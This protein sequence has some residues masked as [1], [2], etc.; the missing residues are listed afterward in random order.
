MADEILVLI[1]TPNIGEAHSIANALVAERLA[2]CVNIV[3]AIE[4]VYRWEGE[5]TRESETLLM[6]KTTNDRYAGV[7]RRVKELHSYSTPE[8][9]AVEIALGSADYLKWLLDSVLEVPNSSEDH[10]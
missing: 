7:E 3:P 8:V 9:I 10:G 6:I 4:S 5:V 1:T 2:A